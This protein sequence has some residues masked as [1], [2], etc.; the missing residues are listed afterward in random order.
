MMPEG[1]RI[2]DEEDSDTS[3]APWDI[4]LGQDEDGEEDEEEE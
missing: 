2:E 4:A 1:Q 3:A